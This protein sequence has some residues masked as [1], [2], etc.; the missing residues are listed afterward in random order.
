M[1]E[2]RR[3]TVVVPAYNE[4]KLIGRVLAEM[5][6]FVDRVVVVDDASTDG[7]A[8]AI[9]AARAAAPERIEVIRHPKNSGV[10]AAIVSGYEAARATEEPSG[11]VAVMA[12]DAQ[13]DP[14]ELPRLLRPLVDGEADY[15][16]GNRLFTGEAWTIIPRYRYLG[17]AVLS[18]LTKIASGYW[19]VTDSQSGYTAITVEALK[20]LQ[21]GR[22]YRRYGFPNHLLVELNNYDFRVR[23]VPIRPIYNI[24]EVSGIRLPRVIPTLAWLLFK[25]YFWRMKEKYIIRD[26]HPLIFFLTLGLLLTGAGF[27]LGVYI[28][29]LKIL[30]GA[31]SPNGVIFDVFILITGMQMLFF[32]MWMD[33]ERNKGLK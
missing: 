10:G 18:L 11:L 33:M 16:K 26:F 9:E 8:A 13:M 29:Y 22:L 31:L 15:T 14:E 25:C 19:H 17:N 21:L 12:G 32:A 4:E 20:V 24:G 30:Y 28:I 2:S 27:L 1:F 3:V 7:T 5:P 6:S 23:D